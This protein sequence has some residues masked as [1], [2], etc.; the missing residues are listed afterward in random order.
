MSAVTRDLA[1][2]YCSESEQRPTLYEAS[3]AAF[4]PSRIAQAVGRLLTSTHDWALE[5]CCA[6]RSLLARIVGLADKQDPARD[7]HVRRTTLASWIGVSVATIQRLLLSLEQAGWITRDQVKSRRR[8][9]QVGE[10]RLTELAIHRLFAPGA[11]AHAERSADR[12]ARTARPASAQDAPV[13]QKPATP[14]SAHSPQSNPVFLRQSALSDALLDTQQCL[15]RQPDTGSSK[16]HIQEASTAARRRAFHPNL[17][18]GLH[19]LQSVGIKP[20]G[21]CALMRRATDAGNRLEDVAKAAKKSLQQ[22]KNPFAYLHAL[23]VQS[24]DWSAAASKAVEQMENKR[25]ADHQAEKEKQIWSWIHDLNGSSLVK[26]DGSRRYTLLG[27]VAM[28]TEGGQPK[29]AMPL[30][31]QMAEKLKAQWEAGSLVFEGISH[32]TAF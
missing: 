2:P 30:T 28:V 22:A 17:P 11:A 23:A 5:L 13:A 3:A 8:G 4:L 32:E 15:H 1:R 6:Q 27:R 20:S 26:T 24:R 16:N 9:F 10:I 19:W 25:Q 31:A 12:D 18:S 21:I 7:I 29:G 14:S